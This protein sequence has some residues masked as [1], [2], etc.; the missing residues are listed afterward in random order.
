MQVS[1]LDIHRTFFALISPIP[2]EKGIET[3][4]KQS[5]NFMQQTEEEIQVFSTCYSESIANLEKKIEL[6]NIKLLLMLHLKVIPIGTVT[7]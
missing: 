3:F 2:Y 6:W 4:A 5:D 7:P 1:F